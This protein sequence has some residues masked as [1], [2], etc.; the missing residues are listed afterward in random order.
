MA[1]KWIEHVKKVRAEQGNKDKPLKEII[2]LAKK[3]YNK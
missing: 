1:N 2:K 3:T